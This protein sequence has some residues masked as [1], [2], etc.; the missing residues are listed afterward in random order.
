MNTY[1]LGIKKNRPNIIPMVRYILSALFAVSFVAPAGAQDAVI[2]FI[3]A[4]FEADVNI[5]SSLY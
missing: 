1:A 4:N 2:R 3:E 5:L